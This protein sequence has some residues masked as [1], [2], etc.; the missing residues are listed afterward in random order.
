MPLKIQ[1]KAIY[2]SFIN[3]TSLE[4]KNF[5]KKIKN[6]YKKIEKLFL[7]KIIFEVSP[8][9]TLSE[10]GEGEVHFYKLIV[11]SA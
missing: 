5:R 3:N 6:K 7:E 4:N 11:K 9:L 1:N 8:Y 10:T 2:H